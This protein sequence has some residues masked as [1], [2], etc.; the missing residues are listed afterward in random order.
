M[1]K[2]MREEE[3]F[4]KM[5]ADETTLVNIG[6][7]DGKIDLTYEKLKAKSK[8]QINQEVSDFYNQ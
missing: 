2:Q 6:L 4:N 7:A 8:E 5:M 1:A 3:E